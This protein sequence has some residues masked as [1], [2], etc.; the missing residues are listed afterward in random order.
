MP[1]ISSY[2]QCMPDWEKMRQDLSLYIYTVPGADNRLN[3]QK[4]AEN[5]QKRV[6]LPVA[7]FYGI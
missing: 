7:I 5:C 2:L 3:I 4:I 6:E 1:N